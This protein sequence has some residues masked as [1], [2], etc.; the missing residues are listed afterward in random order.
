MAPYVSPPST[1]VF[2]TA[3]RNEFEINPIKRYISCELEIA[4]FDAPLNYKLE[5][6]VKRWGGAIVG[7]GSVHGNN[8]F[9]INT[10]PANGDK[11]VNQL[12]EICQVLREGHAAANDSCGLHVHVDARKLD[13]FSIRKVAYLW[14]KLEPAFMKLT[15][16]S[17]RGLHYC[18]PW[19]S[20]LVE[21][22]ESAT[23][24]KQNRDK[25]IE[26]IYGEKKTR[27]VRETPGSSNG[28][29]DSAR[30]RSLN[31]HSWVFRGTLEYRLWAGSRSFK[32]VL[33]S[34][35]L[36]AGLVDFA[37]SH[38]EDEIK[39]LKGS[40]IELLLQVAPTDYNKEW[41][42]E[43]WNNKPFKNPKY[44]PGEPVEPTVEP[45]NEV[46]ENPCGPLD[47]GACDMV[48]AAQY[49]ANNMPAPVAA[50]TRRCDLTPNHAGP[51]FPNGGEVCG[52]EFTFGGGTER[53]NRPRIHPGY[54]SFTSGANA[55]SAYRGE[56]LTQADVA[57]SFVNSRA[58]DRITTVNTR[59]GQ[60]EV[61]SDENQP[62]GTFRLEQSPIANEP[63]VSDT[64]D[65][66]ILF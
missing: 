10:A 1:P 58:N 53:C 57:E 12:K 66:E 64:P 4:D 52:T 51:C 56:L 2:N 6:V 54:C 40:E 32:K 60:I 9:E 5:E 18:A 25:L 43:R 27:L 45:I 19:G 14:E 16:P 55:Y 13:Y 20:R 47:H 30:Y 49:L 38:S 35:L 48:D 31:L 22:L 62:P 24:P 36:S 37:V 59:F 8:P 28:K 42:I 11:F 41:V 39:A 65:T 29:Y 3:N 46:P 44:A 7:D 33:N 50:H 23:V 15:P 21:G 61:V 17:R 63:E 34:A 26:N